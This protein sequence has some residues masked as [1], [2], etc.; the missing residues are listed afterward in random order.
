MENGWKTIVGLKV[1][2]PI[3]E[4]S[5]MTL[6]TTQCGN[7]WMR[8][9]WVL[10]EHRQQTTGQASIRMGFQKVTC[11][12]HAWEIEGQPRRRGHRQKE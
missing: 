10:E 12:S 7:C 4:E 5:I 2:S 8:V 11:G 3:E 6:I 9:E 1:L